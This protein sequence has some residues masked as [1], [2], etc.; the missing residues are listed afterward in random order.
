MIYG[1]IYALSAGH[2]ACKY[3]KVHVEPLNT[4]RSEM[5]IGKWKSVARKLENGNRKREVA[6][7]VADGYRGH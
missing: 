2:L 3:C 7:T 6:C 5:E 4:A 1:T